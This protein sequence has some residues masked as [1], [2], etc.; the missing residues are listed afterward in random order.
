MKKV[1]VLGCGPAGLMAAYAAAT[2]GAF[3][4]IISAGKQDEPIKS[5]IGGAQFLHQPVPGISDSDPLDVVTYRTV[6]THDGY[7]AKVYGDEDVPFVSMQ[8]ISDGLQV[9]AWPLS[10]TYDRLWAEMV[11]HGAPV[12]LMDVTPQFLHDLLETNNFDLVVSSVP[13]ISLCLAHAG[14][15]DGRQHAFQYSQIRV[16]NRAVF[17]TLPN[18]TIRYDGTNGVSWYRT[19]LI[20]GHGSTEWGAGAPARLPYEDEIKS[21]KKPVWTDC[22]C[23]DGHILHVGR[24]GS[25]RK[26]VLAHEAYTAVKAALS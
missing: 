2:S 11:T 19:S 6:G 17:E 12:N 8:R 26:G 13:K 24:Y 18:N 1:A 3:V 10:E 16:V 23:F 25:W 22:N 21:I 7:R 9:P 14:L 5:K 4:S 20:F 15:I